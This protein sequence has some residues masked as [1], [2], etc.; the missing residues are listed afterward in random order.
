MSYVPY[1]T[2]KMEHMA[3]PADI[4]NNIIMHGYGQSNKMRVQLQLQK[5]KAKLFSSKGIICIIKTVR[6]S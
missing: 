5:T 6:Y 2:N 4:H 1:I 3:L